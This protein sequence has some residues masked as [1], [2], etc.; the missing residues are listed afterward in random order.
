MAAK[1]FIFDILSFKK[2]SWNRRYTHNYS[3]IHKYS[4]VFMNTNNHECLG[5]DLGY[6]MKLVT[7]RSSLTWT[8][9]GTC[10]AATLHTAPGTNEAAQNS[11]SMIH[12][13]FYSFLGW[14]RSIIH[15]LQQLAGY[16][17]G[18]RLGEPEEGNHFGS[19]AMV[20]S[21]LSVPTVRRGWVLMVSSGMLNDILRRNLPRGE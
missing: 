17:R 21:T 7:C 11:V 13:C 12:C 5:S 18:L 15:S 2:V 8:E 16:N 9:C 3:K 1:S 10:H 6:P 19:W 20:F 14:L 4:D